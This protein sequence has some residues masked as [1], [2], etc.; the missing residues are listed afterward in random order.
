MV[1]WMYRAQVPASL[2]V[3]LGW[4]RQLHVVRSAAIE[5]VDKL[6]CNYGY[7]SR[8][9]AK[10]FL[11]AGRVSLRDKEGSLR[12]PDQKVAV[13]EVLVD[14]EPI[15]HPDGLLILLHK[16]AGVVCSMDEG[17]GRRVFDLLP[18]QWLRRLP[19]VSAVGRLDKDTTG[20]ILL[21][22]SGDLVHKWCS[23]KHKV[24]KVYEVEVDA[25]I[26][27][28]LQ[29]V[30]AAGELVLDGKPCLPAALQLTGPRAASLTLT[31]GRYHQVK[32]MFSAHGLTV[33]RLHRAR[34]GDF[35]VEGLAAG[36]WRVLDLPDEFRR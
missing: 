34:F 29:A 19:P 2:S 23:P 8:R 12:A 21:T 9:E 24:S 36:D 14:G 18:A 11:K 13:S 4:S 35:H 15:P 26:P 32:R 27:E 30:F 7:C 17:E 20:A 5:R 10:G 6:L 28:R 25:D 3:R 1:V 16:P 31:E 22:D 33:T